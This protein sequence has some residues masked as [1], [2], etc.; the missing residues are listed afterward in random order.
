MKLTLPAPSSLVVL[1]IFLFLRRLRRHPHPDAVAADLADRHAGAALRPSATR[2]DNVSLLGITLAV[3]LVVDDAI[4]MLENI[5]RHVEEGMEPFQA[6]LR[7]SHEMG[8]TIVSISISLV[9]VFIPIF[10]MPGV[11]GL[12]FH[13]FAI[14]VS[15]A[16]LVSAVVSLTLVPMLASRFLKRRGAQEA[17]RARIDRAGSSAASTCVLGGYVRTLDWCCATAASCSWSRPAHPRRH[18]LARSS[19][20]PR[21]SSRPRTSARSR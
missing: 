15:L 12:L 2:L 16:I 20:C 18:G 10:F 3:G 14:V 5:M 4:V 8:F 19:P 9:A 11:I 6:A 13:E 1:V 17:R 21:A 7:G